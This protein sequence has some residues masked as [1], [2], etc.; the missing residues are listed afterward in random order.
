MQTLVLKSAR[1]AEAHMVSRRKGR[2][3]GAGIADARHTSMQKCLE[4]IH[5]SQRIFGEQVRQ[6]H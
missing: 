2:G 5:I 6:M 1:R 3:K 4:V